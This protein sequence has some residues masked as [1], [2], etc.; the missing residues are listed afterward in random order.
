MKVVDYSNY[1]RKFLNLKHHLSS[2]KQVNKKGKSLRQKRYRKK[3]EFSLELDSSLN[4]EKRKISRFRSGI[5]PVNTSR[6]VEMLNNTDNFLKLRKK[7]LKK[8]SEF[9]SSSPAPSK[10]LI[11]DFISDLEDIEDSFYNSHSLARKRQASLK[12]KLKKQIK[13][14]SDELVIDIECNKNVLKS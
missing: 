10:R 14:D 11:S 6:L 7:N 4:L 2:I 5:N 12:K 1:G 9:K 3:N 13:K 8:E